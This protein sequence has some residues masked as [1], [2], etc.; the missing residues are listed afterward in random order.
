MGRPG[1][2][3]SRCAALGLGPVGLGLEH[4]SVKIDF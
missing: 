4:R 3:D 1:V 2:W